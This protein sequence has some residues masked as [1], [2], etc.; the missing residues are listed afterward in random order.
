MISDC[1]LIKLLMFFNMVNNQM[2][3]KSAW[4]GTS[5][6]PCEGINLHMGT[7]H[8]FYLLKMEG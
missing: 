7:V 8:F 1:Q 2:N 6:L 4:I 5:H 3:K